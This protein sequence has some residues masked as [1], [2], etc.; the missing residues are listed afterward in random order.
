M[1]CLPWYARVLHDDTAGKYSNHSSLFNTVVSS[2]NELTMRGHI[3][4][5]SIPGKWIGR[6]VPSPEPRP[7]P[8]TQPW[9]SSCGGMWRVIFTEH[10]WLT[11]QPS[12]K[13]I[14]AIWSAEKGMSNRTWAELDYRGLV[15]SGALAVPTWTW[16]KPHTKFW[17]Q[18][19]FAK[20]CKFPF[21]L[22]RNISF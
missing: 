6:G 14:G 15:W 5:E 3:L 20:A 21:W 19:Q 8:V 22:T 9:I 7:L 12:R 10:P 17:V 2:H 11:L 18:K 13:N 4:K 16:T 1:V